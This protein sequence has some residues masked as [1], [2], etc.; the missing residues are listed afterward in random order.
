MER[1]RSV[2]ASD[3]DDDDAR[4][5]TEEPTGLSADKPREERDYKEYF[6]DLKQ[7]AQLD[8]LWTPPLTEDEMRRSANEAKYAVD[9]AS[10]SSSTSEHVANDLKRDPAS[11]LSSLS[12][13]VNGVVD[14][15]H[16]SIH[17]SSS[18]SSLHVVENAQA[19]HAVVEGQS[20][21]NE[22]KVGWRPAP[23]PVLFLKNSLEAVPQTKF[24]M[25]DANPDFSRLFKPQTE[26]HRP[27]VAYIRLTEPTEDEL[28]ERVEYDM[29][30]Q[31]W[32]WLKVYN[33]QRAEEDLPPIDSNTFELVIDQLE[34]HW[35]NLTKDLQNK[36][37]EPMT[38]EESLCNICHSGECENSNA[39]VFCDGCN[40][41]VHQECYGVP[42]IPEGQWMCRK[43]MLQPESPVVC[44]RFYIF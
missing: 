23:G 18:C 24:D 15:I 33:A 12:N 36:D 11:L 25:I 17:G 40:L 1:E 44:G 39:I 21:F 22:K 10:S 16:A 38:L 27:D 20:M 19:E 9:G 30:E 5:S 37:K 13:I 6:P 28:K 14:R 43:C 32:C 8:L 29:D 2:G 4:A 34:K 7:D 3:K 41:A 26:Y 42:Y 31:D 35:F